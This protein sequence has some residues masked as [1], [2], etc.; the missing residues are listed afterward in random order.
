[1]EQLTNQN[2]RSYSLYFVLKIWFRARNVIGTFEKRAPGRDL[3]SGPPNYRSSALTTRPSRLLSGRHSHHLSPFVFGGRSLPILSH[4]FGFF[5]SFRQVL[6]VGT[7]GTNF[8]PPSSPMAACIRLPVYFLLIAWAKCLPHNLSIARQWVAII[9]VKMYY[10]YFRMQISP[11]L[12]LVKN[13]RPLQTKSMKR[14]QKRPS[15]AWARQAGDNRVRLSTHLS[16]PAFP[17]EGKELTFLLSI[18]M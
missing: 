16:P 10:N 8:F 3:N 17:S 18:T 5:P 6:L 1:M 7:T 12:E 14:G 15:K 2:P 4:V 11:I 13:A 9:A